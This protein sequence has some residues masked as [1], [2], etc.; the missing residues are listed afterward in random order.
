M[1]DFQDYIESIA[2]NTILTTIKLSV[3]NPAKKVAFKK[4]L[5]KVYNAIAA[6]YADDPDFD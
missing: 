3:K 1:S 2:I 6:L 5:L 4:A